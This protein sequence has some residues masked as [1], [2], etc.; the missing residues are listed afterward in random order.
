MLSIH[1]DLRTARELLLAAVSQKGADFVA[2]SYDGVCIYAARDEHGALTPQCIVG[3]VF[4]NL[5]L[6]GLLVSNGAHIVSGTVPE[7]SSACHVGSYVWEN[8][9][10]AGVHVTPEAQALFRG[11]QSKQDRHVPWGEAVEAAVAEYITEA[12]EK[13]KEQAERDLGLSDP[14]G[15]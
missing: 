3:Q 9:S 15:W 14:N 4:A 6:L 5:G 7:Q 11:A 1:I 10:D 8:L 13:A 12:A 2:E